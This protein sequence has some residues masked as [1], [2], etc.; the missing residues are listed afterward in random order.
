M[1]LIPIMKNLDLE[2][3]IASI[4]RCGITQQELAD[5]LSVSQSYVSNLLNGRITN[6]RLRVAE[7][8]L[9]FAK[10]INKDG[11]L[12]NRLKAEEDQL[13]PECRQ[14]KRRNK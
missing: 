4:K 2:R 3:A 6:P 13:C 9:S 14:Y 12:K 8:I 11:D 10:M 1:Q 7:K 5:L